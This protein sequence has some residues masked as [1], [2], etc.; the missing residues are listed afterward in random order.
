M[1]AQYE[2][3]DDPFKMLILLAT[4]VAEQQGSKLDYE[5]VVPFEND[6]FVLT[7]GRFLYK[8]D[9]VEITWYQFLGR[10]IQCNKD[11]TR[12]E[13]NRMFVDCMAS[14]YGVS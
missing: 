3:Y 14:V 1:S 9:Q 12:Q 7:N 6:K 11:L 4:F 13:Y 10:D 8:K 2:I 5:N